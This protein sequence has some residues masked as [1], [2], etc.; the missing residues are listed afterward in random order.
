M[1]VLHSFQ[2]LALALNLPLCLQERTNSFLLDWDGLFT[3]AS[4]IVALIHST[5]TDPGGPGVHSV[6]CSHPELTHRHTAGVSPASLAVDLC[7]SILCG[8]MLLALAGH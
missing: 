4:Y 7:F 1:C 3:A 2:E 8:K 6:G 5:G